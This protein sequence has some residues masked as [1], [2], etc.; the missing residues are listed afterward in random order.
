LNSVALSHHSTEIPGQVRG[1][2]QAF[3]A[4]LKRR[5]LAAFA[6]GRR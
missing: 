2:Y 6:H 3:S 1:R 5:I 4:S